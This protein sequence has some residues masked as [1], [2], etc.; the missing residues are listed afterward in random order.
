MILVHV[1][2]YFRNNEERDKFYKELN[3][4]G[5]AQA[6]RQ[7][8]GNIG[9]DYY[10]PMDADSKIFLLEQWKDQEALD[11]HA[12][13]EHFARLQQIKAKYVINFERTQY[14][15]FG[16]L[17]LKRESCRM[18]SDKPVSREDLIKIAEAGRLTPSACNSQPWKFMIADEPE[19]KAKVCDA[20]VL[21]N[22]DTGAV[23]RNDVAAFIV[24]IEENAVVKPIVV[25]YYADSQHF[26][27]GDIGAAC[28]NMCYQ[29]TELGISSCIIGV[30]N[31]EK[32][33]KNFGIPDG[34]RVKF[35]LA[36]GYAKN[37]A[38]PRKK[39]RKPLE[40]VTCFN[41]YK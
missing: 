34:S 23:W 16:E 39:V 38:A 24:F 4:E 25:D 32:W 8:P 28:L 14:D 17:L 29:A 6:S 7:E 41:E 33:E 5:I 2:Y 30:T 26:A 13:M 37:D 3:N 1:N 12:K 20:L 11:I 36:L 15:G 10:I 18:Y 9:Y 22:G 19:A 35:V 40:E 31:K 21:D 27:A